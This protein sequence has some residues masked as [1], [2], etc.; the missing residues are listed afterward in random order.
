MATFSA[1]SQPAVKGFGAFVV[2][3][4]ETNLPSVVA[5]MLPA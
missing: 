1:N 4:A 5:A 2:A 3:V